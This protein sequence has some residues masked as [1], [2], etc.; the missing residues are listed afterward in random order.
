MRGGE[1]REHGWN[2][3]IVDSG[4]AGKLFV[5]ISAGTRVGDDTHCGALL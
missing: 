2:S 3:T 1:Q 4:A 5:G